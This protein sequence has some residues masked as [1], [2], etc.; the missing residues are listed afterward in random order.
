MKI[1]G[2]EVKVVTYSSG[3]GKEYG[4]P[5][6]RVSRS[7]PAGLRHFIYFLKLLKTAKGCDLIY[8]Q[9]VTSAGLPGLLA[10]K[11]LR[12]GLSLKVVGDA[13]WEQNRGYLRAIQERVARSARIIIVPSFYLKERVMGWGVSGDKIEVVYNAPEDL[14][15]VNLS[16]EDAQEKILLTLLE[17]IG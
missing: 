2:F 4:F 12:V 1:Q 5:V 15:Q 14:A 17:F 16:K 3:K 10:A 7:F 13:A 6:V 8:S 11:L 9:N